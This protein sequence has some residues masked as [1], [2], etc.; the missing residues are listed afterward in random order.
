MMHNCPISYF[1]YFNVSI[2]QLALSRRP[3]GRPRKT[4][5]DARSAL[6]QFKSSIDPALSGLPIR[7][8]GP[9]LAYRSTLRRRIYDRHDL[10]FPTEARPGP[11]WG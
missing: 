3:L 5:L 2:L 1:L 9:A 10:H 11:E 8:T 4:C 6:S 7:L